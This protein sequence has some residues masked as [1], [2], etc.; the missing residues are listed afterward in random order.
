M[1]FLLVRHKVADYDRW[2]AVFDEDG[3]RRASEG[4]RGGQVFRTIGVPD[5]VI[6]LLEW[7]DVAALR[8]FM[9]T[10]SDELKVKMDE[11]G[12]DKMQELYFLDLVATSDK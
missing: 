8:Q 7:S 3:P 9:F 4:S 5:E 11:A 12:V 1:P 2:K 10:E 6:V